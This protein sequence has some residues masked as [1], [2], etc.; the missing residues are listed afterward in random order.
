VI[1]E[2]LD[3]GSKEDAECD[4]LDCGESVGLKLLDALLPVLVREGSELT[5]VVLVAVGGGVVLVGTGCGVED[6]TRGRTIGRSTKVF[7]RKIAREGVPVI[8]LRTGGLAIGSRQGGGKKERS[9]RLFAREWE[10]L[11]FGEEGIIQLG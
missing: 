10:G 1:D 3:T 7:F 5:L 8:C 4:R 11:V 9:V 6:G 2:G